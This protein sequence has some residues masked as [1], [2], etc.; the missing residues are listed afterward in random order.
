MT[1]QCSI[2]LIQSSLRRT[3]RN[4]KNHQPGLFVPPTPLNPPIPSGHFHTI[5]EIFLQLSGVDEFTLPW[6]K[7][8]LKA[9]HA[10]II[11]PYTPHRE[12][13]RC[14]N[15]KF[16]MIVGA[17]KTENIT[18]HLAFRENNSTL[19]T[20]CSLVCNLREAPRIIHL[21][22]EISL[23]ASTNS[24]YAKIQ[25]HAAIIL[26]LTLLID[27]LDNN[28]ISLQ[29]EP[30]KVSFCKYLINK[31][32]NQ[33]ELCV[34]FLAHQMNC[35]PNY[36]SALFHKETGYRLTDYINSKRLD[37][38]YD[39]LRRNTMT[40]AQI[41]HACGYSDPAYMTR[42]FSKKFGISPRAYRLH[43]DHA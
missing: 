11:P 10:C 26:T 13:Y 8:K 36:L 30:Y 16:A 1:N 14:V 2:E 28:A 12:Y 37:Q 6:T 7:F 40:I 23:A 33:N 5:P 17:C 19:K 25:Q 27:A 41:A 22:K 24:K 9:N 38:V 20:T 34:K 21:I 15:G 32:L 4:I 42:L 39:L 3:L 29:H 31:N 43:T 35:S 18:W